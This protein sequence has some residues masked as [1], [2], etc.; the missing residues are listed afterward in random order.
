MDLVKNIRFEVFTPSGWSH[1]DGIKVI[2]K[3][4]RKITFDDGTSLVTSH[5]HLLKSKNGFVETKKLIQ[6]DINIGKYKEWYEFINKFSDTFSNDFEEQLLKSLIEIGLDSGEITIRMK[7]QDLIDY[8]KDKDNQPHTMDEYLSR[9]SG[10]KYKK[11]R[12]TKKSRK[13][14][15]ARKSRTTRK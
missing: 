8:V 14:K 2:K 11:N 12:K 3:D 1:F 15:R 13:A 10:G 7:K 6:D 9:K 5:N 4:A